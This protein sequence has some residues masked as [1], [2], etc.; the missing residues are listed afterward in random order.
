MCVGVDVQTNELNSVSICTLFLVLT[1]VLHS[2]KTLR[3]A[4]EAAKPIS[5]HM[6]RQG[7]SSSK[8]R[9]SPLK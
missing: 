9:K 8:S 7:T 1:T 3:A 5:Y 6:E 2:P 4:A